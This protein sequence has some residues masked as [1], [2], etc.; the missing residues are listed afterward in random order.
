MQSESSLPHSQQPATCT[1]PESDQ[2]NPYPPRHFMIYDYLPIHAWVSPFVSFPQISPP[3]TCLHLSSHPYV[4][5]AP[6]ISIF[7]I[8]SPEQYLMRNTDQ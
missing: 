2:S 5:H 7:S 8:W 6:P 4:L 1:Y 3:L